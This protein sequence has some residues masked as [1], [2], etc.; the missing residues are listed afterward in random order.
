MGTLS[1]N[2]N[3]A[4]LL[5]V[6]IFTRAT[7]QILFK[8]IAITEKYYLAI[9]SSPVFYIS[10]SLFLVQ[11]YIWIKVLK[12]TPLSIA[13]PFTSLIFVFILISGAYFFN[14]PIDLGHIFGTIVIVAGVITLATEKPTKK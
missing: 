3:A 14:E 13:Y 7:N 9:L 1:I 12:T 4:L 5:T 6:F 11:A 10:C 8:Y 2:Y